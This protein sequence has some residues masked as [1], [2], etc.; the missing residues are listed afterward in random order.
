MSFLLWIHHFKM[1]VDLP[2]RSTDE[3]PSSNNCVWSLFFVL[4]IK[5]SSFPNR[6]THFIVITKRRQ[7]SSPHLIQ[8]QT[9]QQGGNLTCTVTPLTC[10]TAG[11]KRRLT[12]DS[13]P[14]LSTC[15][16]CEMSETRFAPSGKSRGTEGSSSHPGYGSLSTGTSPPVLRVGAPIMHCVL[17]H[18]KL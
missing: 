1:W 11:F 18:Q 10:V 8:K 3:L 6:P 15:P 16:V 4:W 13:K 17:L 9:Q 5:V 2:V 12:D 7:T 14:L